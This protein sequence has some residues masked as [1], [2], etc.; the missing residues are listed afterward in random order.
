VEVY[1]GVD[2]DIF[3]EEPGVSLRHPSVCL[4]Q[5]HI[6]WPKVRGLLQF[7][8]VVKRMPDVHFYITAGQ[9][10]KQPYAALV[11]RTFA[12]FANVHMLEP[13]DHPRGVRQLLTEA[14]LYLLASGLDMCPTSVLEA[15]LMQK[16]VVASRVGG[17]PEIVKEGYT[18]YTIPNGATDTW[19][20]TIRSILVDKTLA[21]KLGRNGKKWVLENFTLTK[22]G[23]RMLEAAKLAIR[24]HSED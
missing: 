17:V 8:S 3:F 14:D 22:T 19:I 18:G 20:R 16:P 7:A 1:G 15:S 9:R 12:T 2:P 21:R 6:I 23:L 11:R 4:I 10:S 13:V 24:L 5:N